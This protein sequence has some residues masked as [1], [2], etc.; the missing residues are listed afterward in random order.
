MA[1]TCQISRNIKRQRLI[2]KHLTTR[3]LLKK[4]Q[5]DKKLSLEERQQA[6]I[7]LNQLPKNSTPCRYVRRCQQTGS[8]R[9]VYRKFQL[10]RISLRNMALQ[11]LLPGVTKSSW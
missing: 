4:A 8:A 1:R 3:K 6:R 2:N 10:N 5:I 11:G 9:S 7:K